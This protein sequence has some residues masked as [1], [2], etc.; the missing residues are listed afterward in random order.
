[1]VAGDGESMAAGAGVGPL[2]DIQLGAIVLK[3]VEV[4][5]GEIGEGMAQVP[6]HRHGRS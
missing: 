3:E 6:H 4:N 5:R 2:D 1:M